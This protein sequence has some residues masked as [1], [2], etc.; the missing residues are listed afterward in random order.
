MNQRMN[1]V[2]MVA[3]SFHLPLHRFEVALHAIN[4]DRAAINQRERLRVFRQHWRKHTWDDISKI[5][6]L[7][8][9]QLRYPWEAYRRGYEIF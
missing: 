8:R 5:F 1:Q 3:E 7:T 9:S 6:R 4:P 2:R